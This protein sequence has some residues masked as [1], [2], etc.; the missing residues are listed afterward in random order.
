MG[1]THSLRSLEIIGLGPAVSAR[2][3]RLILGVSEG[4][5]SKLNALNFLDPI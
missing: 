2:P 5:I 1:D 4:N 3:R